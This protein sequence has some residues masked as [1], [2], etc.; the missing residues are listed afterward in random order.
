M[1]APVPNRNARHDP[2]NHPHAFSFKYLCR[3][4]VWKAWCAMSEEYRQMRTRFDAETQRL[5]KQTLIMDVVAA[6]AMCAIVCCT[7]LKIWAVVR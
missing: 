5:R 1:P 4:A 6:L 7:L 2:C 3:S